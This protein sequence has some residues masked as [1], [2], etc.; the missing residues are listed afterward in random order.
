MRKFGLYIHIPFCLS[1]C[2]YCGFYSNAV[3]GINEAELFVKESEYVAGVAATLKRQARIYAHDRIV[4]TIYLGGGTPSI[5]PEKLTGRLM[6]VI[7]HEFRISDDCEVTTEANPSTL[8]A[9]KLRFY[10]EIG[11]NRLS[12]GLQS[13]DSDVL[14]TLGRTHSP[15][16]F[17]ESFMLARFAGFDNISCDI[18][19]GVPGQSFESWT[20]TVDRLIE[21]DPEHIS[22]YGL[23]LE[24]GT[25]LYEAYRADKLP[26]L[27]DKV[28]RRMYHAAIRKLKKAGYE[29]YEI[30]NAAKPG[31]ECRHNLKYWSFEEYLGVGTSASSFMNGIRFTEGTREEPHVND[32]MDDAGEFV[33]TGLRKVTGISKKEF[34]DRFGRGFWDVYK[35]VRPDLKKYFDRGFLIEEGDNLRLSEKG[36][37]RSNK[38]MSYFV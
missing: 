17:E 5:L 19:F 28:D 22:F 15:H 8:T 14:K 34:A 7:R 29:H 4:D 9:G 33:F 24:E 3:G 21:L 31:F 11:I 16:D 13:F 27:S 25:P 26:L 12:I 6:D 36:I 2:K 30:S 1:R 23:Q 10:K 32:F 20:E 38:I 18:M 37:D 35:E